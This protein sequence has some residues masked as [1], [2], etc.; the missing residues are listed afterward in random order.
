MEVNFRDTQKVLTDEQLDDVFNL[1]TSGKENFVHFYYLP[2][3]EE[4]VRYSNKAGKYKLEATYDSGR[5]FL[6]VRQ[7]D[8]VVLKRYFDGMAYL[9]DGRN[10]MGCS[11]SWYDPYYAI[12]QV[13]TSDE[14]SKMTDNELNNLIRLAEEIQGA[15]Y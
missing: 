6:T 7:Q 2:S 10:R 4:V 1:I 13:F 11:E 8:R 9:T 14:V 15:L 5:D 3:Y 12:S